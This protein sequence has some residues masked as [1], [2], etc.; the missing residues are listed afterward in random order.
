[1]GKTFASL[2]WSGN[3]PVSMLLFIRAAMLGDSMCPIV[4]II[5]GPIPSNPIALDGSRAEII[6]KT[7][8]EVILGILKNVSFGT[9]LSTKCFSS[10][11]SVSKW[12]LSV[13][14][15]MSE[16]VEKY[17]FNLLA[18][19]SDWVYR[20]LSTTISSGKPEFAFVSL[21]LTL[22]K[23]CHIVFVSFELMTVF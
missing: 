4:L 18:I 19:S 2:S 7:C 12:S 9:L 6:L 1:M 21:L 15:K 13:S 23:C 16:I 5:L 20:L 22:L 3:F 8:S 10:V 17:S 11:K 14:L